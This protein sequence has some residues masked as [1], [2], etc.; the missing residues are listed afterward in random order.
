MFAQPLLAEG[1]E[2]T[3]Q[4]LAMPADTNAAGDIFGGWLMS[5]VDL[6]GSVLAVREA[7]GRVATVAVKS[8]RFLAPV[9][10]GD[11]VT[12]HSRVMRVGNTSIEVHTEVHAAGRHAQ[13]D[14]RRVA[15]ATLVYVAL[16]DK[17]RP[18]PVRRPAIS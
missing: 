9:Q 5:Q 14:P 3:Y 11:L 4:V 12:C 10:V 17:G 8:F 7:G 15:E 2:L 1:Y 6:G 13:A 16:N 18:R